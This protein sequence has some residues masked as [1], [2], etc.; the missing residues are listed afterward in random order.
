MGLVRTHCLGSSSARNR[1]VPIC[2]FVAGGTDAFSRLGLDISLEVLSLGPAAVQLAG[3]E[4]QLPAM[5]LEALHASRCTVRIIHA[6]W[7][8]SRGGVFQPVLFLPGY[9]ARSAITGPS[10]GLEQQDFRIFGLPQPLRSGAQDTESS[11]TT[12]QPSGQMESHSSR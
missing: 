2:H 10:A 11:V 3:R 8:V 9:G 12:L 1:P 5:A 7:L 4:R 6:A